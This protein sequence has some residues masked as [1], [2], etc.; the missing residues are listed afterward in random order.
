MFIDSDPDKATSSVNAKYE[1]MVWLGKFGAS[2]QQIGL[3]EG[4]IASQDINGTTFSLYSGVNGLN[5]N[6]LT[7]VASGTVP[8]LVA[9]IGP[10]LQGLTGLG[11]P[12]VNDYLG[13]LAFGS[14][15]LDAG[16]NVTFY[17]PHLS[18]EVV[19]A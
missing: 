12:T 10:L 17:N 16:T 19:P 9:D 1:V 11:G 18:M 4:A 7:W 8:N 3:K 13:Y 15:A 2:T 6:V 14:E 5:Q